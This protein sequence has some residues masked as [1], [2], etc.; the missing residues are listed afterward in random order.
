MQHI[1][2]FVDA[3]DQQ[4]ALEVRKLHFDFPFFH[5]ENLRS[6]GDYII[7]KNQRPVE[8]AKW[9]FEYV[10]TAYAFLCFN[11]IRYEYSYQPKTLEN[12]TFSRVFPFQKSLEL[13]RKI[14]VRTDLGQTFE[15]FFR[16][17]NSGHTFF[18]V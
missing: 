16:Q 17:K 13:F 6:F 15:F 4:V 8:C 10:L 7:P 14:E 2:P 18:A 11:Q 1:S 12:T 9:Y 3:V 5:N